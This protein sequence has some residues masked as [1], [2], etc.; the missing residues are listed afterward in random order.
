MS[1]RRKNAGLGYG[2]QFHGSF[3]EKKE[4]M[5]KERSRKGAFVR[6]VP[7]KHGY[8]YIV[9]SPRTN[10]PKRKKKAKKETKA[11]AMARRLAEL[12]QHEQDRLLAERARGNPSE[13]LVLGANPTQEITLP[14]NSTITIRTNPVPRENLY[15]GFGPSSPSRGELAQSKREFKRRVRARTGEIGSEFKR[16]R[17]SVRRSFPHKKKLENLF[18]ELYGQN[19]GAEAL[20]ETFTGMPAEFVSVHNEP[21]MQ[22]GDYAQLGELLALYVTP[23]SGGQVQQIRFSQSAT[24]PLVVSDETARQIYFVGGDQGIDA[25]GLTVFGARER[26]A[27]LF[28]LGEAR[29]IDYKQRKEHVPQPNIDEWKHEFGEESGVRPTVLYDVRAQRLLLE[30]GEYRIRAEGIIN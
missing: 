10:P 19:P 18:H 12:N 17:R 30:G 11:V 25:N 26:G 22:A 9:M 4:A 23:V 13:L 1:K 3:S 5:K 15:L 29:R 6:G 24:R 7:T 14:P 2:M 20:R 21:H 16:L 8:R 28:E 27:G